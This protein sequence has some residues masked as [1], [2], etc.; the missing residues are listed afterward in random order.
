MSSIIVVSPTAGVAVFY[1]LCR[2][3]RLPGTMYATYCYQT[4][5]PNM[6]FGTTLVKAYRN[7]TKPTRLPEAHTAILECEGESATSCGKY[8]N[9]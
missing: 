2:L 5:A 1:R 9:L 4:R 6:S 3:A 7:I 8:P